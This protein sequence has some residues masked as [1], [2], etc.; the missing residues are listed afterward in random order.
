[1][2]V[3]YM[4]VAGTAGVAAR[5]HT[6]STGTSAA[7]MTPVEPRYSCRGWMASVAAG[8]GVVSITTAAPPI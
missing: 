8:A 4:R 5:G 3:E 2:E 1:M 6:P 7:S